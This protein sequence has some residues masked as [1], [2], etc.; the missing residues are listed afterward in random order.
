MAAW[1][2][3]GDRAVEII[4]LLVCAAWVGGKFVDAYFENE[5]EAR[6]H[7]Y[8]MA[9]IRCEQEPLE[10]DSATHANGD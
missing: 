7:A 4:A 9:Q 6:E 10:N 5:H 3:R 2:R 8:R 1:L